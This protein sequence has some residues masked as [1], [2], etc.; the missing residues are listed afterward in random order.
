MLKQRSSQKKKDADRFVIEAVKELNPH[1]VFIDAPLSLP[2]AFFGEGEDYFYREA[3]KKLK[4]MS[5]MFL[6]GLTARAM[7]LKAEMEKSEINVFETYPGALVRSISEL[8][9]VYDKKA[10]KPGT[11]MLDLIYSLLGDYRI[12]HE[13]TNMHQVDSI[14]AWYSGYRFLHES[15]EIVGNKDEG[16]IVF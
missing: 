2:G 13:L 11:K 6:G 4:A 1:S 8:S 3:D 14:L 15:A 9:D 7:K 16:L 12:D 10:K 5:P